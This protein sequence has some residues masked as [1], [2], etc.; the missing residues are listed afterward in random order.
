MKFRTVYILFNAVIL[1]SFAFIFFLPLLM[2]GPDYFSLFVS[3]NWVAGALFAATLVI[4]NVYFLRNWRLFRLLEQEDWPAVIRVL[5]ERVLTRRRLSRSNVKMLVNAYLITSRLQELR[6]LAGLVEEHRPG[7][8]RRFALH[9][10]VPYLLREEPAAAEGYF[11]R[12][13]EIKGVADRDWLAWNYGFA[14]LQ[15]KRLDPARAVLL[16]IL[17]RRP[18]PVLELLTLYI[19]RSALGEEEQVRERVRTGRDALA[20]RFTPE[21]WKR[22]LESGSKNLEV[23]LLSPILRDAGAWLFAPPEAG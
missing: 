22:R 17:D 18:E 23:V 11:G 8:M 19:L 16:G 20:R 12:V 4:V 14:L 7:L 5:E 15:Q 13:R 10:G 6:E 3:R 21:T 1:L 2:L 9:F